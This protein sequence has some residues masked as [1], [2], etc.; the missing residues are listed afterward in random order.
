MHVKFVL[1]EIFWL[2]KRKTKDQVSLILD[3]NVCNKN[4]RGT[5][6]KM[7]KSVDMQMFKYSKQETACRLF[8]S[9]SVLAIKPAKSTTQIS[10]L[11]DIETI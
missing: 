6:K 3:P 7:Q 9:V 1:C 8:N 10:T 11:F 2:K 5:W 4:E